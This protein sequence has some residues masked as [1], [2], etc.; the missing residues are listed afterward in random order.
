MTSGHRPY[1]FVAEMA[2]RIFFLV[3]RS[4]PYKMRSSTSPIWNT[5]LS[6]KWLLGNID[7]KK[8]W[9]L[10]KVRGEQPQFSLQFEARKRNCTR[11]QPTP[12]VSGNSNPHSRG[13]HYPN[14]WIIPIAGLSQRW[15]TFP[16]HHWSLELY[17]MTLEL[18]CP[19]R[20]NTHHMYS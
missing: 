11:G 8:T 2:F 10:Y 19:I 16:D 13:C 20:A 6:T 14:R 15:N 5:W 1:H 9:F 7:S 17:R 12:K 3:P 18:Q 4:R